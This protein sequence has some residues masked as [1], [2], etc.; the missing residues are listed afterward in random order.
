MPTTKK[1]P[2]LP[3]GSDDYITVFV[4]WFRHRVTGKII[5]SRTGKPFPLRVRRKK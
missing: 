4:M 3:S 5:R 2:S 1:N